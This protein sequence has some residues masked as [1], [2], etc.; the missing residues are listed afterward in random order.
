MVV[1]ILI[2]AGADVAAPSRNN[3]RVTAL[4]SALAGQDR[5][6]TLA[7]IAAGAPVNVAQQ[8]GYT[9]LHEAAQNGDRDMVVAL[10][11]AGADPSA[12]LASG[13]RPSDLARKH[14]HPELA[15]L[16]ERSG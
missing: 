4:H 14:D 6:N 7:L 2:A 15:P 8:D 5:E 12:Q 3:M 1:K 10:L 13:D 9:P 11:A 16:L